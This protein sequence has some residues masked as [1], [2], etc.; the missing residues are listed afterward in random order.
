MT[1][2]CILR[3]YLLQKSNYLGMS[4]NRIHNGCGL[5]EKN[6]LSDNDIYKLCRTT[7]DA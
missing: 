5:E 6:Y 4:F 2:C 3:I 1:L 7:A